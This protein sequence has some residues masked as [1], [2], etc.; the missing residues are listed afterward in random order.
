[1]RPGVRQVDGRRPGAGGAET[2][3]QIVQPGRAV[4][5]ARLGVRAERGA[6]PGAG[7]VGTAR[8]LQVRQVALVQELATRARSGRRR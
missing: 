6:R 5:A 4:R 2:V 3:V 7:A 1:M 8:G